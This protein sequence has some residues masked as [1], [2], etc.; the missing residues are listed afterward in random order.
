M[1]IKSLLA[2]FVLG[3]VSLQAAVPEIPDA[4]LMDQHANDQRLRSLIKG[5]QSVLYFYSACCG[6]CHREMAKWAPLA[7]TLAAEGKVLVGIT[8]FGNSEICRKK[9]DEHHLVGKVLADSD[10]SVCKALGVGD[11]TI[12][13]VSEKGAILYKG[14][15]DEKAIRDSWKTGPRPSQASGAL[16]FTW[17]PRLGEAYPDFEVQMQDG[18]IHRISGLKGK[19]VVVEMVGMN[20]PA[21]LAW[22]GASKKGTLDGITPQANLT[23]IEDTFQQYAGVSLDDPRVVFIQLLLFNMQMKSPTAKDVERWSNHFHSGMKKKP[24]VLAGAP[25]FLQPPY[26]QKTYDLIPGFQLIDK[27]GVLR[28]DATGH[29]PRHNLWS[30]LLPA[31]RRVLAE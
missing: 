19:I 11:F 29:N 28:Y 4:T 17:P 24:I 14:G 9:V 16:P 6:H 22:A 13:T 12:M 7:R 31:V 5:K 23:P 20:C 21:C 30:D 26:Y 8:Y 15:M 1:K 25:E 10:G 2:L 27:K 18:K 3:V